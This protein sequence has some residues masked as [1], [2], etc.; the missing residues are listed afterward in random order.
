MADYTIAGM[1]NSQKKF[2]LAKIA[3]EAGVSLPTVSR[4]VNRQPGV[5]AATEAKVLAALE[6]CGWNPA[7]ADQA[8]RGLKFGTIA[9]INL[10]EDC[11]FQYSSVVHKSIRGAMHAAR[12]NN[13]NFLYCTAMCLAE[14]P[15][16]VAERA[17]DGLILAGQT[18]DKSLVDA[19]ADL[20][21]CWITSHSE[22]GDAALAG[23]DLIARLA[24]DY[25]T[26]RGHRR[27]ALINAI[28][29]ITALRI[30][31]EYFLF[32]AG[33]TGAQAMVCQ[34]AKAPFA[35]TSTEPDPAKLE[36]A[37]EKLLE[38]C[39]AQPEPATGIFVP[40]DFQLAIV[41][42]I[43]RRRGIEP[44]RDLEL[45]GCDGELGMLA[46]LS[47]RPATIEIPGESIGRRAVEQL[48]L[49]LG[50]PEADWRRVGI[51]IEPRL[52]PGETA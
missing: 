38:E 29:E 2:S 45:I 43:L 50:N 16:A 42:R 35:M 24:V 34:A 28:P 10:S 17:V 46:G 19:L 25:L 31:G 4:V 8:A 41:H 30:R 32:F 20:P 39:L 22:N 27:L 13:L 33:R 51:V 9:L 5:A 12:E 36:A 23:N 26:G 48:L 40:M 37:L 18:P 44:G 15:V 21:A 3:A 14:L 47:P 11:F 52:I 7:V 1:K 6:R 49:R